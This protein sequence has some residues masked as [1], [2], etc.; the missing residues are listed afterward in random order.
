LTSIAEQPGN[1]SIQPKE[2]SVVEENTPSKHETIHEIPE[3]VYEPEQSYMM[4]PS[5]GPSADPAGLPLLRS[6]SGRIS[7]SNTSTWSRRGSPSH[8]MQDNEWAQFKKSIDLWNDLAQ[9]NKQ[10][11]VKQSM[12]ASNLQTR[13]NKELSGLRATITNLY[14]RSTD[15]EDAMK[16][17][18]QMFDGLCKRYEDHQQPMSPLALAS[19]MLFAKHRSNEGTSDYEGCQ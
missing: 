7:S 14:H 9:K 6:P 2:G 15:V 18:M 5:Q 11:I 16:N 1:E 13:H 17:I 12:E 10:D 19:Q 4:A 3:D 8:L